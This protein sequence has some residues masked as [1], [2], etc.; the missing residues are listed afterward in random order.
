MLS[1]SDDHRQ[2]PVEEP[3][4]EESW[5]AK[6]HTAGHSPPPRERGNLLRVPRYHARNLPAQQQWD[7][8]HSRGHP[9]A[10]RT[11]AL[12]S[13][14]V[15]STH[16]SQGL[17]YS[18]IIIRVGLGIAERGSGGSLPLSNTHLTTSWFSNRLREHAHVDPL[19][20]SVDHEVSVSGD[21]GRRD[22]DSGDGGRRGNGAGAGSRLDDPEIALDLLDDVSSNVHGTKPAHSWEAAP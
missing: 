6:F 21:G 3:R 8:L 14:C 15:L 18:A 10:R 2:D 17:S 7:V 19:P 16:A 22:I 13:L 11:C 4:G 20:I 5:G 9:Y 1:Y 12:A